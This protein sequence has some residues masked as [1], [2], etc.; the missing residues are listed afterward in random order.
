MQDDGGMQ[1][2]QTL[3]LQEQF[4]NIF[5]DKDNERLQKAEPS[6]TGTTKHETNE[7]GKQ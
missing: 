2:W 1:Y 7:V 6:K 4:N 3:G 5:K